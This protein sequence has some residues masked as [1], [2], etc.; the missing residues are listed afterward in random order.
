[1]PATARSTCP[2][3]LVVHE[4]D[5]GGRSRLRYLRYVTRNDASTRSTTS[6]RHR[7]VWMVPARFAHVFQD[8]A[9]LGRL[10]IR[11]AGRG[12]RARWRRKP[13]SIAAGP[14]A[15]VRGDAANL[16]AAAAR[17]GAYPSS[18]GAALAPVRDRA[19]R[20]EASPD[21]RPLL[22]HRRQPSHRARDG[23]SRARGD[24]RSPPSRRRG[25]RRICG[26]SRSSRFPVKPAH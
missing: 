18:G 9:R 5:P 11:G 16:E 7:V 23:A 25:C 3:P 6:R 13:A 21:N 14:A 4:P 1:M 26:T 22:R 20:R 17:A 24:G 19:M 8:A 12:S 15:G 10:P 2:T